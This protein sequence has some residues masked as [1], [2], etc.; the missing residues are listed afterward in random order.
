MNTKVKRAPAPA[1]DVDPP[2]VNLG[3]GL[4]SQQLAKLMFAATKD[5]PRATPGMTKFFKNLVVAQS[6][7]LALLVVV[8]IVISLVF[9]PRTIYHLVVLDHDGLPHEVRQLYQLDEPNLT[10]TAILNMSMNVVTEVLTF[11]FNN[12]DE[13]LLSA[14]HLFTPE[15]WQKFAKAYLQEG[16]LEKIKR[17]QQVL[18]AIASNGAVIVSEGKK[19]RKDSW[20][21]QMPIITTFQ[22]GSAAL[23]KRSVLQL[24]LVR[25][26]TIEHPEGVAI[27]GWEELPAGAKVNKPQ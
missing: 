13:R 21:V 5:E 22:A 25:A 23:P 10:H 2:E 14:R 1:D 7:L 11:G 17:N 4:S 20:V 12:A 24:T 19:N 9:A 26:S 15:A 27:D 3:T 18:T 8:T 16:R 6:Y